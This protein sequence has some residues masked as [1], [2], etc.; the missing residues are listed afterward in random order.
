MKAFILAGGKGTRLYPLTKD[1]PK[2]LIS[3]NGISIL[4]RI[5]SLLKDHEIFDIYVSVGYLHSKIEKHLVKYNEDPNINICTINEEKPLGT[6]GPLSL[7]DNKEEDIFII[8]GDIL[9]DLNI[10]EFLDNYNKSNSLVS[11]L[12]IP[13]PV[14]L[15]YG[16]LKINSNKNI[17][18]IK[19]KPVIHYYINGGVYILNK[20]IIDKIPKDSYLDMSDFLIKLLKSDIKINTYV[21]KGSWIDTGNFN[22]LKKAEEIFD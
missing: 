8:N 14:Q 9:T 12:T 4:D 20:K 13:Y 5:I 7:L 11:I 1:T 2:P 10:T 18:S 21:H 3:I 19:E 17:E 16:T 6:V 22:D 15:K